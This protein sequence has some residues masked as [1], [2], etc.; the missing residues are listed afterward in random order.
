MLIEDQRS[1]I[2]ASSAVRYGTRLRPRIRI[3]AAGEPAA[4][5]AFA[6]SIPSGVREAAKNTRHFLKDSRVGGF[7]D[8]SLS[9]A[10]T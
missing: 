1:K 7:I 2:Y 8:S 6:G 4:D 9:P 10:G 5:F 3:K